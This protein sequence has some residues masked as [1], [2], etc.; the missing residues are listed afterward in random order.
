[1][2]PRREV[3]R[4]DAA[5]HPQRPKR[6]KT[7]E[8]SSEIEQVSEDQ[9]REQLKETYADPD[10]AGRFFDQQVEVRRNALE[11]FFGEVNDDERLMKDFQRRPLELLHERKL[12]G[13]LDRIS[14]E[15]M[16]NPFVDWPW[17]WPICRIVCRLEP[18]V[19]T[20]WQCISIWPFGR[21]CWPVLVVRLRW[22]CRIVCD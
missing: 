12:L 1:V 13:P 10:A 8:G 2:E 14:I 15:D 21:F 18:V 19:E 22:Q 7:M 4:I 17:P 20:V 9:F 5:P 11:G 3:R 6:R 16:I